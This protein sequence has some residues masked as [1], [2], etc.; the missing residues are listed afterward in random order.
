MKRWLT[1]WIVPLL[2]MGLGARGVYLVLANL[3]L[4]LVSEHWVAGV[5]T[6][7]RAWLEKRYGRSKSSA[8]VPR[9]E[10]RYSVS[11]RDYVGSRLEVPAYRYPP[12]YSRKKIAG[13]DPGARI[14]I[15]Y[16]PADPAESVVRKPSVD[17]FQLLV[18]GSISLGLIALGVWL[19]HPSSKPAGSRVPRRRNGRGRRQSSPP[20]IER[21]V[22]TD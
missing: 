17:W 4:A 21:V 1:S 6:V 22:T 18:P 11:G 19:L 9:V 8:Y 13:L 14:R 15:L 10:Y 3:R 7:D 12:S 2:F 20:E 5:A 16:D